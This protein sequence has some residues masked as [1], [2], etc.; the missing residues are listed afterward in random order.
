[1]GLWENYKLKSVQAQEEITTGACS[2]EKEHSFSDSSSESKSE[3][4]SIAKSVQVK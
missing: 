1:M 3:E 4:D 2:V